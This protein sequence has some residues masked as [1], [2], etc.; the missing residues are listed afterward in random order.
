MQSAQG[1]SEPDPTTMANAHVGY[2][3]AHCIPLRSRLPLRQA[4]PAPT[5]TADTSTLPVGSAALIGS[6]VAAPMQTTTGVAEHLPTVR[7]TNQG[8]GFGSA[9]YF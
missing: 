2:N 4:N 5:P 8:Q 3:R 6:L 1:Q 9:L 7:N